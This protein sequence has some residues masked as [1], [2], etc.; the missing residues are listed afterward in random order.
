M[1]DVIETKNL[2]KSKQQV[3]T[4]YNAAANVFHIPDRYGTE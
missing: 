1:S 4:G 2:E 3:K